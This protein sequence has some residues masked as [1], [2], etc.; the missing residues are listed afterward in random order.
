MGTTANSS[1]K[2][3]F[4]QRR[5]VIVDDHPVIRLGLERLLVRRNMAVCGAA[6]TAAEGTEIIRKEKPD[7]A[8][9][10]VGLPDANGIDL[11]RQ[12]VLDFPKVRVVVFSMHDDFT[13]ASRALRA[14]ASA[15]VAKADLLE[16]LDEALHHVFNGNTYVSP[17]VAAGEPAFEN[18]LVARLTDREFQ[19]FE[20]IGIGRET[21]EI[22][23]ELGVSAK[24][25]EAHRAHIK[26]K[27]GCA[28]AS[29][30]ARFATQWVTIREGRNS[31]PI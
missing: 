30:L 27:L 12:I 21:K 11:T 2:S 17:E 7:V 18:D 10:D 9:I 20:R 5:V 22:A 15:Y 13:I 23:E 26:E 25:V 1:A 28:K 31:L 6:S 24:T 29:Q 8:L 16:Q 14:G 4:E 3:D 19:V